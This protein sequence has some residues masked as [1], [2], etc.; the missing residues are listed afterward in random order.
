MFE[1]DCV[2]MWLNS[3]SYFVH[4]QSIWKCEDMS[5]LRLSL[6]FHFLL[7]SSPIW[8]WVLDSLKFHIVQYFLKNFSVV[9][10]S[11]QS[12]LI[13]INCQFFNN[14]KTNQMRKWERKERLQDWDERIELN[15]VCLSISNN[16][17]LHHKLVFLSLHVFGASFFWTSFRNK[18][19]VSTMTQLEFKKVTKSRNSNTDNSKYLKWVTSYFG[20]NQENILKHIQTKQRSKLIWNLNGSKFS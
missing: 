8:E 15:V 18:L 3:H 19:L 20:L 9:L 13:S 1:F 2:M 14:K 11:V 7:N 4:I 10:S 5:M 6:E 12:K 17:N 16:E